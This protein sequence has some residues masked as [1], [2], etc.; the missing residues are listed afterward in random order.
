MNTPGPWSPGVSSSKRRGAG[1]RGLTLVELVVGVAFMLIAISAML[2]AFWTQM[3][4]NEHARN[5]AW[6]ANDASRVMERVRQQN[7]GAA[8]AVPNL[9]APAG[10]ASWDA[11]LADTT[12]NGGGGKSVQPNGAVNEL[13]VVT[14]TGTDPVTVTVAVCWRSR[15]R[16]LGECTWSGAALSANPGAGGNLAITESPVMLSTLMT[17]RR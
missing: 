9:S 10:F 3:S 4:L 17:C 6:A 15:E 14:P 5:R 8:C 12:A 2:G 13:V 1:E 16:T 7:T 11:W